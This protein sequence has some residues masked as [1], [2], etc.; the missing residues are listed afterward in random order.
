MTP[1]RP[2]A[3][4]EEEQRHDMQE[5]FLWS[6]IFIIAIQGQGGERSSD[7]NTAALLGRSGKTMHS[8]SQLVTCVCLVRTPM[9]QGQDKAVASKVP[10]K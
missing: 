7:T 8:H 1:A 6:I 9:A 5:V 2:T 4:V 10:L 3:S